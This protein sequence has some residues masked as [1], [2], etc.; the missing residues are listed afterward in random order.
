M[1]NELILIII[2][3][4]ATTIT[5]IIAGVFMAFSDFVMRSLSAA[6]P[7]AGIQSMQLINRKVYGSVFLVLLLGMA[8]V[9]AA[10]AAYA[11]TQLT[12]A[13]ALW[14]FS[15]GMIYV[16]GVFVVTIVRNVPMNKRLDLMAHDTRS[17]TEYWAIYS[18]S[19]TRW[20][21]LRTLASGCSAI[22]YLAGVLLLAQGA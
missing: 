7:A 2:I 13:A 4:S 19:W 18:M 5:A 10:I 21:H 12:G 1:T 20:N 3:A 9:S 11:Y 8:P 16:L 22:C 6:T 14:L 15:G 17:A